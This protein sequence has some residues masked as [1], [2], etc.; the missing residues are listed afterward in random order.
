M[1]LITSG[2]FTN[3][4]RKF[5]ASPSIGGDKI[6]YVK[7]KAGFQRGFFGFIRALRTLRMTKAPR[8]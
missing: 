2:I 7:Q 4:A 8:P 5:G 6:V 1:G 3:P